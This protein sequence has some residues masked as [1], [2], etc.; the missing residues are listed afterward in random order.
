MI[1]REAKGGGSPYQEDSFS[2]L[3]LGTS[4]CS[5]QLSR[6]QVGQSATSPEGVCTAFLTLGAL[7]WWF[8]GKES[9]CKAGGTRSI[10]GSGRSPGEGSGNPLQYSC[11][12]NPM[13]RETWQATVHG[14]A[15]SRTRLRENTFLVLVNFPLCECFLYGMMSS[16]GRGSSYSSLEP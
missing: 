12:E 14:I 16:L 10:P 11:L 7:P 2:P 6:T 13:D 5:Q 3:W 8:S 4:E 9:A 1:D 15:K